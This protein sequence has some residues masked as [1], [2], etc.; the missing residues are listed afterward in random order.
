MREARDILAVGL[1]GG[2]AS[3]KSSAARILG[4]RGCRVLDADRV[5]H[6]LLEPSQPAFGEVVRR[7]GTKVLGDDGRIDRKAVAR[8][9]FADE[10]SRRALEGILHPLVLAEEQRIHR[11]LVGRGFSG[12]LVTEAALM[13]EA[14]AFRRYDRVVVVHAP[15]GEPLRRLVALGLPE[16]GVRARL[17]AQAP[18]EEK[19]AVADYPV[20]NSGTLEELEA[21]I[22]EV[23][24]ALREDWAAKREGRLSPPRHESVP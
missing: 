8:I 14:G 22:G 6:M 13:V 4:E 17:E 10:E 5:V 15:P 20:E 2:M 9:V 12:I 11:E 3:G 1:T 7:L 16:A 19:L 23:H 18:I 24:D 21:R